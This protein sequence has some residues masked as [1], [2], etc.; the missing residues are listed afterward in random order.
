[1]NNVQKKGIIIKKD[2]CDDFDDYYCCCYYYY[3]YYYVLLQKKL[4][5]RF[6]LQFLFFGELISL[7]LGFTDS[8]VNF[9]EGSI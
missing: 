2:Y 1:M 5:V 3:Y 4:L 9:G 6:F 8:G 7:P